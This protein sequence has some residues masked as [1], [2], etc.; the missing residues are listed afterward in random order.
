MNNP[1]NFQNEYIQYDPKYNLPTRYNNRYQLDYIKPTPEMFKIH[2][3]LL[4]KHTRITN[5]PGILKP[6]R[7]LNNLNYKLN[8]DSIQYKNIIYKLPCKLQPYISVIQYLLDE[9]FTI[10]EI[11]Q[12]VVNTFNIPDVIFNRTV[13]QFKRLYMYPA[14]DSSVPK[15][16]TNII[17]TSAPY[18]IGE[19]IIVDDDTRDKLQLIINDLPPDELFF[20]PQFATI[21]Y[22]SNN[23]NLTFTNNFNDLLPNGSASF[24]GSY[25]LTNYVETDPKWNL[26]IYIDPHEPPFAG[27]YGYIIDSSKYTLNKGL[28]VIPLHSFDTLIEYKKYRI[29]TPIT[30]RNNNQFL[31]KTSKKIPC[32]YTDT[33]NQ[34]NAIPN[35]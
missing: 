2:K 29:N 17:N 21:L 6:K 23:D 1:C 31:P 4:L 11:I 30:I 19:D 18:K 22:V 14:T 7:N 9:G 35:L 33:L 5:G 34:I 12:Y 13:Y 27:S 20:T 28:I 32:K 8:V 25:L 10:N 15:N 26:R 16:A 24:F 3:L